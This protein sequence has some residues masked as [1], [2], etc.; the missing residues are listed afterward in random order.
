MKTTLLAFLSLFAASALVQASPIGPQHKNGIQEIRRRQPAKH[1]IQTSGDSQP[2]WLSESEILGLIQKRIKFMDITNHQDLDKN[3]FKALATSIPTEPKYQSEVK[4]VID[5]L[6][7]SVMKTNLEGFIKFNNRYYK[8]TTGAE[9]SKWLL[10]QVTAAANGASNVSV[11]AFTHRWSQSSVIAR[12]EGSDSSLSNQVVIV[13]AHQDSI[14]QNNPTSGRAP[15]ADDDGSGSITILETFRSLVQNNFKPERPVEF[16]WYSAE[17]AGLLGSQDIA[18]AYQSKN[19]EVVGML[20]NDMTGYIGENG[21]VVGVVTDYVDSQLTDFIR[22]LVKTYLSIPSKDTKCGYA[23]SDHGSWTKAGYPSAFAIE[24]LFDD[25]N[26]YIH[27]EEDTIE[28]VSFDHMK[29]FSKLAAG[30]AVELSHK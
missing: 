3:V 14:N 18:S 28:K 23:C 16:H 6:D 19:I 26:Q 11:K 9:S 22:K 15:G 12:F 7:T 21:E 25:S 29:E 17:E 1:L 30:F 20:Q 24:S 4:P 2:K 27:S 8:S 10:Q 5:K 13:G